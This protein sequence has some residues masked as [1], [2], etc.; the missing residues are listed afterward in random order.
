MKKLNDLLIEWIIR[1]DMLPLFIITQ[2]VF[3]CLMV[4]TE[5]LAIWLKI[6]FVL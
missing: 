4:L 6:W 2:L 5:I 3:A 1:T